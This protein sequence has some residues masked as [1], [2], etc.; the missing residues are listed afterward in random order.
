MSEE[1]VK[2]R[3]SDGV[4][5]TMPLQAACFSVLVKNMVDDASGN[6]SD[7]EIPLP[8]VSSK[9]L[10]KVIQWCEYHVDHSTSIINKPLKMGGQL[11][12]N[13]VVEW[14]IKFLE[15]PEKELFDVMLAANFM[16]IKPLLE[17]CCASVASSIKSKTVE[18]LREELGVGE[19]GFTPEEEEKI[20]RDNAS[21]CKEAADMLKDIEK[22]KAIQ[23]AAE[24][25]ER[26]EGADENAEANA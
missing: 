8:N 26:S 7:E 17:L 3:T 9:I 10:E 15:M 5:M 11:R 24:A 20:L 12:D 6:I 14:D 21:W 19:E 2:L 22:E 25:Q 13:G 4:V 18:E 16:D 23:A 1:I